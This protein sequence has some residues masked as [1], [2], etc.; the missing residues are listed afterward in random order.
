MREEGHLHVDL[1][2]RCQEG[3]GALQGLVAIARHALL[4]PSL[5]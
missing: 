1:E 2:G 5:W 4:I 3:W